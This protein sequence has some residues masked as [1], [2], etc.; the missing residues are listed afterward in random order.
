MEISDICGQLTLKGHHII[1]PI[2]MNHP[3]HEHCSE[4]VPT[5]WTFWYT[6]DSKILIKCSELWVCTLDGWKESNGVEGEIQIAKRLGIP[7]KYLN[8]QTLE[9]KEERPHE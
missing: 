5:D 2:S 6:Y 9:L 3:W 7:V 8:P 4:N 1:S